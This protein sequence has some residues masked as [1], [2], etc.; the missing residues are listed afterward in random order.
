MYYVVAGDIAY[1]MDHAD[2]TPY[3]A[4]VNLDG[5]VDWDCTFNFDSS[6]DE[7]DMEYTAH[8]L[9]NLKQIVQ[10]TQEHKEVYVK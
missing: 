10:L 9:H 2:D 1:V 3:G 4:A 8:V 5:T 6:M 7:E